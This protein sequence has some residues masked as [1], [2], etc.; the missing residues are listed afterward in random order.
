M[1]HIARFASQALARNTVNSACAYAGIPPTLL[2]IELSALAI[3]AFDD[4]NAR[5]TSKHDR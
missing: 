5:K 3:T 2:K 1:A 4:E